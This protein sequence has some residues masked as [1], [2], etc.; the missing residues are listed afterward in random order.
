MWNKPVKKE[1]ILHNLCF[2]EAQEQTKL[3]MVIDIRIMVTSG[4]GIDLDE[5]EKAFWDS[6]GIFDLVTGYT[7]AHIHQLCSL[8]SMNSKT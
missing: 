7:G 8:C 6:T 3:I 4:D 1:Y 5:Q 2:Y